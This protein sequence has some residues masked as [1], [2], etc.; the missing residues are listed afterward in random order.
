[1]LNIPI[2]WPILELGSGWASGEISRYYNLW[3]IEHNGDFMNK[4]NTNYVLAPLKDG[5]Y[6]KEIVKNHLE[7]M[8]HSYKLIL[9]DGPDSNNRWKIMENLNLFKWNV[10]VV[11]D[12]YQE[13][14]VK[15]W[16]DKLAKTL[17]GRFP[18]IIYGD[19]KQ[20]LVIP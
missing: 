19:Y 2:G 8:G 13:S 18:G 20:T 4:Y 16:S 17:I 12:D 15:D 7:K 10:P 3:S 1:M 9:I 11:I 5:W 14:N 6:D